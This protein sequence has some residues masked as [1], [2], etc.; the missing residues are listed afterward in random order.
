M[1]SL[2][3]MRQFAPVMFDATHSVQLP[4]GAGDKSGGQREFVPYLLNA[5]CAIGIDAAFME[6]HDDPDHA[7]SDGPNMV[8]LKDL[9]RVLSHAKKID[10]IT[11]HEVH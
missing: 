4:G 10:G 6:I 8:M 11:K 7:L 5:A 2:I 9:E 3:I 1:R